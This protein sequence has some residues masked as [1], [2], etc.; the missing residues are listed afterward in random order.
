MLPNADRIGP[1]ITAE[2]DPRVTPVGRILRATKL[3]ELPQCFNLL[4]GEM[5][6]VGPRPEVEGMVARYT[7]EQRRVLTVKP[8][9][10]GLGQL[11]YTE[12]NIS[13]SATAEEFYVAHLLGP[14]VQLEIEYIN[15]RSLWGDGLIV[16]RTA[17]FM[18]RKLAG[19]VLPEGLKRSQ[20]PAI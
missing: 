8:G 4:A 15:G 18:G 3:D 2:D 20:K 5:T 16:L 12:E 19:L 6:L 7:P 1:R 9:L 10:T 11:M 13:H 17:G 14:K